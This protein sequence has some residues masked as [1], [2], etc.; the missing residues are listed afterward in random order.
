MGRVETKIATGRSRLTEGNKPL[1]EGNRSFF[2]LW[3]VVLAN[4]FTCVRYQIFSNDC[5]FMT[6]LKVAFYG[7]FCEF[8]SSFENSGNGTFIG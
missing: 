6:W 8:F 4:F 3:L 7:S 5:A 1:T 2:K